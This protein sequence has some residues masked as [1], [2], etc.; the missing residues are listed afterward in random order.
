M[1]LLR[2]DY[3][4]VEAAIADVEEAIDS[5]PAVSTR[6]PKRWLAVA[7]VD[8][9]EGAAALVRQHPG[10]AAVVDAADAARRRLCDELGPSSVTAIAAA[11][12]DWINCVVAEVVERPGGD[13]RTL[14]D[15]ID[16][17]ATNRW[18]GIP[19]F[20]AAMWVVFKLTT[21]VAAVFMGWIGEAAAGPV[22]NFAARLLGVV[23][24][25]GSWVESLVVDGVIAGVGAVLSFIPI[26]LLLFVAL[27][28]LEDTG[29]MARAAFV[30]DR[31]MGGVGL[32]GKAF[33]P[34][35][36]GFGCTV[37]AIYAT[38]TLEHR[39]DRV[40]TGLLV[41]FMS[42]GARLPVY[43]L[44]ASAFFATSA[45][46]AV[47]LM[48]LLGIVVALIVGAILRRTV[49]R[50]EPSPPAIM[51]LPPY[52]M[53]T[54]RSMGLHTWG[55]MK[56]FLRDAGSIILVASVVVWALMAIPVSGAGRFADTEVDDSAFA[57][58][59]GAV[60]PA[61]GPLGLGSWEAAGS[62]M[63]GFV[64]KEVVVGTLGQVYGVD[65]SGVAPDAPAGT[66]LDDVAAVAH[67]F[68]GA[69]A[70]TLPRAVGADPT[71]DQG[72]VASAGLAGRIQA[73][74]AASS[75]GHGALA[76]AAFMVFVLLYTPCI[77]AAGASRREL[78]ARWMGLSIVGQTTLAWVMAAL[79]FQVGRAVGL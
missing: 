9:D 48:Y 68:G 54:R 70:G 4:P 49:L 63:S 10:G 22:A 24:L 11:R 50:G 37:P 18:L 28:V 33:L 78:G 16:A 39:R 5:I 69:V 21:D 35:L 19:I 45:G 60:A 7:L 15:R 12:Y 59:A 41:P 25:S 79:V 77:A 3:G 44:M 6:L 34:M 74:F 75:G 67:G 76:G 56:A 57:A 17:V 51:E 46:T 23:G 66:P 58:A 1:S 52:R 64:A 53:P 30:M 73:E 72:D 36:V 8:G 62:L 40:L 71:R 2:I 55:R 29:Y 38:R 20:L 43:V 61:L 26:L 42:C 65:D 32:P 13:T 14:T 47:F 31:V 27:A